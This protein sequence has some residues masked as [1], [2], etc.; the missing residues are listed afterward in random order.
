MCNCTRDGSAIAR[1]APCPTLFL[2]AELSQKL[3]S[4]ARRFFPRCDVDRL[5][6]D[7]DRLWGEVLLSL[8]AKHVERIERGIAAPI[9]D[10]I[11][12]YLQYP[13]STDQGFVD[14]A[15]SELREVVDV[16]SEGCTPVASELLSAGFALGDDGHRW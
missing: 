13:K 11:A 7:T 9:I 6:K 2:L 16:A 1:I 4:P 3:E 14:R 5:G 8:L 12:P 15:T 10:D